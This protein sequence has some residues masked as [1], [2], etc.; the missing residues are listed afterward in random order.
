MAEPEEGKKTVASQVG[1]R[2]NIFARILRNLGILKRYKQ[3]TGYDISEVPTFKTLTKKLSFEKIAALNNEMVSAEQ[4]WDGGAGTPHEKDNANSVMKGVFE[5]YKELKHFTDFEAL[6]KEAD[7]AQNGTGYQEKRLKIRIPGRAAPIEFTFRVPAEKIVSY[8]DIDIRGGRSYSLAFVGSANK[9]YFGDMDG[10]IIREIFNIFN[11]VKSEWINNHPTARNNIEANI[12]NQKTIILALLGKIKEDLHEFEEKQR[13]FLVGG[14]GFTKHK[15]NYDILAGDV[16]RYILSEEKVVYR[17]TYKILQPS[18]M[19]SKGLIHE[20]SDTAGSYTDANGVMH[21]RHKFPQTAK[22]IE[23]GVQPGYDENGWPLEVAWPLKPTEIQYRFITEDG[24]VK[25]YEKGSTLIDIFNKEEDSFVTVRK[26]DDMNFVTDCDLVDM[27]AWV[28]VN[29]DAYRDDLRDGR[30]HAH[31]DSDCI[32]I[33]EKIM[34]EYYTEAIYRKG[35]ATPSRLLN[36]ENINDINS[37]KNAKAQIKL[38]PSGSIIQTIRP[39]HLNPAFDLSVNEKAKHLGRKFY[40]DTQDH[41]AQSKKKTITTRG[42]AL[43]ILSRAVE[44]IKYWDEH[45]KLLEAIGEKTGGYDIGPNIGP[46]AIRWGQPLTKN[47]YKPLSG[48]GAK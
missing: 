13:G 14:E 19:D 29:Y 38:N 7:F 12:E 47:P 24:N 5:L 17:H 32:T 6:L 45:I 15:P 4:E 16:R 28:Y 42:A 26:I 35:V 30:Y 46:G 20:L 39:S 23:A 48:S 11:T 10:L 18:Y 1:L 25:N 21:I 22:E 36:D 44:E 27:A 41:S 31:A 2:E 34:A 8:R 33:M 3:T 37:G 9:T 43:Y 40:Y